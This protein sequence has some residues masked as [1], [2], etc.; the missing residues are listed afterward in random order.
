MSLYGTVLAIQKVEFSP[1]TFENSNGCDSTHTIDITILE[2]TF[3]VDTQI[4]CD[5][6]TWINGIT[7]TESTSSPT[8]ALTNSVGCDSVVT[9]NLSILESDSTFISETHCDQLG[10][11][12]QHLYYQWYLHQLLYQ[13]RRM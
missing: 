13:C 1:N 8:Y 7:Y 3:G 11:G 2:S 12:R 6:Y 10:M 9:L 4:H 5:N